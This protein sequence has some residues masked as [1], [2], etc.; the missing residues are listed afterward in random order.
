MTIIDNLDRELFTP[1]AVC[2]SEGLFADVLRDRGI[3]PEII[4][5]GKAK[6]RYF[7]TTAI[8]WWRFYRFIKKNHFKLVHVSGLQEAKLAAWP[9]KWANIPMVWVVAP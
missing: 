5:F 3:E 2:C 8:A 7:I 6:W 9:C 1:H 4:P